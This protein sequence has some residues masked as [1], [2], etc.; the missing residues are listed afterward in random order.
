VLGPVGPIRHAAFPSRPPRVFGEWR[1]RWRADR[2]KLAQNGAV[3]QAIEVLQRETFP[4]GAINSCFISSVRIPNPRPPIHATASKAGVFFRRPWRLDWARCCTRVTLSR[5]VPSSSAILAS[6]TT[7]GAN[8]GVDVVPDGGAAQPVRLEQRRP[9]AH[10]RVGHLNTV[11]AVRLE[12]P[13]ANGPAAELGQQQRAEQRARPPREPVMHRDQRP[14][15]LLDLFLA[16]RH[17]RPR[18]GRR[19]RA[20]CSSKSPPGK[21]AVH[22][23]RR[24]APR[25]RT[26]IVAD[27][28]ASPTE[29]AIHCASAPL[30]Y[31][32]A[33]R[34]PRTLSGNSRSWSSVPS[35]ANGID[36]Y[37]PSNAR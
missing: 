36:S 7:F 15:V 1:G 29:H 30:A 2:A 37:D 6:I 20:R 11:Q 34:R 22:L 8:Y 31:A 28:A 24:S 17:A 21:I 26:V 4:C 5:A 18:K 9:A 35:G 19:S 23:A 33:A 10:E 12:E 25:R 13:F 14:V 16:Q 3:D 27:R 32:P